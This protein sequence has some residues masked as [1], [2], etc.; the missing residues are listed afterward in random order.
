[1]EWV[2]RRT[3]VA[4]VGTRLKAQREEEEAE[5][6]ERGDGGPG[7]GGQGRRGYRGVGGSSGDGSGG[8]KVHG[9]ESGGG[10]TSSGSL[11]GG[12]GAGANDGGKA[13]SGTDTNGGG[14][15]P[16]TVSSDVSF[17]SAAVAAVATATVAL[18]DPDGLSSGRSGGRGGAAP[19]TCAAVEEDEEDDGEEDDVADRLAGIFE[20]LRSGNSLLLPPDL[21]VDWEARPDLGLGLLAGDDH[22]DD[23]VRGFHLAPSSSWSHSAAA[24]GA[25]ISSSPQQRRDTES[26]SPKSCG[27]G[28]SSYNLTGGGSGKGTSTWVR[29]L[30]R[31]TSIGSG[32]PMTYHDLRMALTGSAPK[33]RLSETTN[34]MLE[35]RLAEKRSRADAMAA[36]MWGNHRPQ[37]VENLYRHQS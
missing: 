11:V 8:I 32:E 21:R 18:P 26:G 12:V 6:D 3:S 22:K 28:G 25:K 15:S 27:S 5:R 31:E 19:S 20:F 23:V 16:V 33:G 7:R 30:C 10:S 29:G 35:R 14:G 13:K 1:M 24:D 4:E 37:F 17:P 34:D 9:K 36:A 2:L